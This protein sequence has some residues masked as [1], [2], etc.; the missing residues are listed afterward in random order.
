MSEDSYVAK[1]L[2][3]SIKFYIPRTEGFMDVVKKIVSKYGSMSLIEF[4]GYFEGKFEPVKYTRLEVHT[5]S[6]N[7]AE[8]TEYANKIRMMLKQNSLAFEFNNKLL[9]VSKK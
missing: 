1:V 4:D 3:D 9:L 2:P 8:I 6:V 7:E 5:A